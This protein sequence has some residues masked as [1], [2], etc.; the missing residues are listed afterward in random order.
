VLTQFMAIIQDMPGHLALWTQSVGAWIYVLLFAIIFAETG[1]IVMPFL[2]GDSLLFAVGA[3]TSVEGGLNIWLTAVL[4]CIAAVLGDAVNYG[5]GRWLGPRI[6]SKSGSKLFN[7][8]HLLRT[9][10]FYAKHGG[11]TILLARFMP[12]IRTYAPFVAGLSRMGYMKFAAYNVAGGLA[13][14]LLFL[15]AGHLFGNI[16]QVKTNFHYVIAAIILVSAIPAVVE[17]LRARRA[18]PA[19]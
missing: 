15:L 17:F 14:V 6:F 5:V 13:W 19:R 16:P 8:N 11:K 1:L 9:E 10:A 3:I 18:S 4:L 12:I 2:P 7:P